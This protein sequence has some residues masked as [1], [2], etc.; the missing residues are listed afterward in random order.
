[1][2]PNNLESD[3]PEVNIIIPLFNEEDVFKELVRRILDLLESAEIS[4]SVILID[5]GS[6]DR[7]P[8]LMSDLARS[9]SRFTCVF[10]SRNF[11]H[12][13]A[14]SAGMKY[15]DSK[16]AVFILDGDLQDPPELMEEFYEKLNEGYDVVYA[17]RENRKEN[18]LKKK[19]YNIFY[20]FLRRISY[21]E[22][23]LNSGDFAMVS[24][25]VIDRL[26]SMPEESRFIRGMRSWVGFKQVGIKYDRSSRDYGESK[27]SLTRLFKLAFNGIF[28]FSEFP[29]KF[30]TYLGLFTA[31]LSIL[32]FAIVLIKRLAF[33]A[34]PEGFTALLF[35]ILLFGGVQLIAIGIIGEYI[36][37][38]FFQTK[39][40]PLFIVDKVIKHK[41][42]SDG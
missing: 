17:I 12:Q 19:A 29:I 26:N 16:R 36:L 42:E 25:R 22:I 41:E 11:G 3:R 5:D 21:I 2:T 23:P 7:T 4:A 35:M 1:M 20:K 38:I 13:R 32:Y 14:L 33:D 9:D 18:W 10:L 27:Y 15:V 6:S 34:V 30:I 39:Q 8:I 40:R 31:V 28:N 24:R 37:R